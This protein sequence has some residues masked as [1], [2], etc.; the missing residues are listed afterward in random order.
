MVTSPPPKEIV[1][2]ADL[3]EASGTSSSTGNAR[4]SRMRSI[5]VPTAPV[6]PTTA[7]FSFLQPIGSPYR[8]LIEA[9]ARVHHAEGALRVPLPHDA[10]DAD[11]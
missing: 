9:E 7:T 1:R 5:S 4:S 2:P 11:R 10:R 8:R 3:A 6:A